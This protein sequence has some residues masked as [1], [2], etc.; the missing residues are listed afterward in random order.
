MEEVSVGRLVAFGTLLLSV[1][2]G[3]EKEP[4]GPDA[5]QPVVASVEVPPT[6]QTLNAIGTIQQFTAIAKDA[7]GV[8][9]SGKSL[10]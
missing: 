10:P 5:T 8:T 3:G 9:I 4:A 2:C 7:S 6:E 1:A